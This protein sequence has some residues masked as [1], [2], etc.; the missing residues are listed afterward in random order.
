M[1]DFIDDNK[2]IITLNKKSSLKFDDYTKETFQEYGCIEMSSRRV[3]LENKF[4]DGNEKPDEW[5]R[6]VL[7]LTLDKNSVENVLNVCD[8]LLKRKDIEEASPEF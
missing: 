3:D 4:K 5:Y 1:S 6:R 7:I 8:A 2:V